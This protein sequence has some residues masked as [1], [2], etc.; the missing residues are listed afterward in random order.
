MALNEPPKAGNTTTAFCNCINSNT[1]WT[2]QVTIKHDWF[3]SYNWVCLN[4]GKK[5]F[6]GEWKKSE[7]E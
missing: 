7:L 2:I 1:T 6:I 4:C 5:T 3:Y